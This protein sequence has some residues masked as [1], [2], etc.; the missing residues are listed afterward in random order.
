MGSRRAQNPDDSNLAQKYLDIE[1]AILIVIN[2][3]QTV[4]AINRK[5]CEILGYKKEEIIG[6]DWCDNF[7]PKRFR[8]PTRSVLKKVVDGELKATEYHENPIL[9][10]SG[11]ERLIAWHNSYLRGKNGEIISAVSSGEDITEKRAAEDALK[12][13]EEKFRVLADRSLEGI[14]MS[15]GNRIIFANKALVRLF[16]YRTAEELYQVPLLDGVAPES[17][18]IIINIMEKN[19]RS[20]PVPHR[21]T[22]KL[23]RKSGEIRDVELS[24]SYVKIKGGE[25]TLST[26]RDITEHRKAEEA[27]ATSEENYCTLVNQLTEGLVVAQGPRP[28]LVFANPAL[29]RILGYSNKELLSFSPQKVVELIHPEDRKMFFSRF[30]ARL[31]GKDVPSKY[32]FRGVRKDKKTIWVAISSRRIKYLDQPSV[33][34]TF[35]DITERKKAEGALRESEEKYRRLTENMN[36]VIYSIDPNGILTYISPSVRQYGFSAD[37]MASH[38]FIEF[39]LPEDV[40]RVTKDFQRSL[41]TR[42]EFSTAFRVRTKK[43]RIYWVE[44]NGKFQYD[45]SG[46]PISLTGTLRDITERKM[47]EEQLRESEGKFRSII[48]SSHDLITLINRDG[49]VSYLS[50]ACKKVIGW[51]PKLLIGKRPAIFHP[52]DNARV[53]SAINGALKGKGGVDLQYRIITQ[54]GEERWV[55]HSWAPLFEGGKLRMVAS[56]I[57]DMTSRKKAHEKLVHQKEQIAQLSRMKE[58]FMADMTHELK[59]PLSVIMLNLEMA[60]KMDPVSQ[61]DELK[62]CFD[63]MWRN[64]VR[65]S[66]SV[67]QIMQLT[68]AESADLSTSRF[69]LIDLIGEVCE[70]YVPIATTKGIHFEVFGPDIEIEGNERLLAMAVSNL[71]SNA[72]KFTPHGRIKINWS[73]SGRNA[74][75]SVS[76]TGVGIRPQN[77]HKVFHKF[78]KEDH[79]S[80][81]S[82]I[83]LAISADVIT[84][85]GGRMEFDSKPGK[86]STFRIIIPKEVS[87]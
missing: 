62:A 80:P 36:D 51:D 19:R 85:M 25:F 18:H 23:L 21:F 15:Q 83:G 87:K 78:F 2:S 65:L 22:Y 86:G 6:K 67:E 33:Q 7:L 64:S 79:D 50:P 24:F 40:E 32:E 59:T 17:R 10:K 26:F 58:R 42:T 39:I 68:K 35:T 3:D 29:S 82:G 53:Q 75:I 55:S 73:S 49:R 46:A 44:D 5:G 14:G 66:R 61:R 28:R 47:A 52:D 56:V 57:Q 41:R 71:V 60:K 54:S 38:K 30:K 12:E 77:L 27:L 1:Q 48:E 13:S 31:E 72:I 43:G 8:E 11:E 81:G 69:H 76:D 34:A 20:L 84:R 63:L 45:R 4:G 70:E 16:G 74:V 9:T 37:K